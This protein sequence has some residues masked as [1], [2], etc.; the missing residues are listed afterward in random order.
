M[1]EFRETMHDH[2][3]Q[4]F[5]VSRIVYRE[6]TAHQD[7]VIFET[8]LFGRVLAL[9]GSIQTTSRDN[10]IYHEMFAHVP[11]LAHGRVRRV[12]VIGGGDGG[13]LREAVKHDLEAAV[14]VDIDP[15]V[16]ELCRVHMPELPDGAF[17]HPRARITIDDGFRF[18]GETD[19]RFE[20]IIVDSTDPPGPSEVLFT[21]EFYGRCKRCLT[22]GGVVA[23]M[24][25]TPFLQPELL[26][27]SAASLGTVFADVGFYYSSVPSYTG[28]LLAMGFASD[29]ASLRSVD[30]ETLRRRFAAA[31]ITTRHYTPEIHR[32]SFAQPAAVA[33]L[34][35]S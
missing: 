1:I 24:A 23:T 21:P 4:H 2:Y 26:Q 7:L 17:D 10:H 35:A 3:G 20:V 22:P 18:V 14:L 25:G 8:P 11:I 16:I 34:L 31:G 13:S 28:G 9:D 5:A 6:T 32:A 19:E 12:L 33:A 29:D 30:A 27:Q 15:A